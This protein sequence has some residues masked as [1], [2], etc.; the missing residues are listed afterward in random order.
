M[1]DGYQAQRAAQRNGTSW[2]NELI[3][4]IPGADVVINKRPP[5]I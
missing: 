3:R 1:L 4:G 5:I 2:L